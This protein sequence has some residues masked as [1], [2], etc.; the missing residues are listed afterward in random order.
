MHIG[1]DLREIKLKTLMK[2]E[3]YEGLHDFLDAVVGDSISPAICI[4]PTCNYTTEMEPDQTEGYCEACGQNTV[5]APL[6]LAEII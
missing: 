3:G 1:K 2:A 4:E 5:V 6:I